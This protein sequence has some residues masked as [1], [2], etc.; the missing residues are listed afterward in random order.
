[1]HFGMIHKE[2]NKIVVSA[3][4]ILLALALPGFFTLPR[5]GAYTVMVCA[6][7]LFALVLQFFR[8]PKRT[9]QVDSDLQIVAPVDGKV[10]IAEE[11]FQ[12]EYLGQKC[13][14]ISL[15]MNPLNVHVTRYPVS[16]KV[17]YSQYHPGKYWVAWHPKSSEKNERTTVVVEAENGIP[18]LYKQI[19]G[20]VAR[21]IVNYAEVG[22]SVCAGADSGFIKFGSRVDVLLPLNSVIK[23]KLGQKTRGGETLI[24]ELK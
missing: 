14:Q 2:G 20:A 23:V 15:F 19:A 11:I 7:V 4:V 6:G 12:K 5:G 22:R 17:V 13:L 16:G 24:A 10:V 21:R 18:V 1:M 9:T 8:N 3:F